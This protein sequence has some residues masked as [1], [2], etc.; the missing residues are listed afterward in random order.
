MTLPL[1]SDGLIVLQAPFPPAP[2]PYENT[3]QAPAV[4]TSS[5]GRRVRS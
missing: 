2:F 1:E 5:R 4:L 3:L